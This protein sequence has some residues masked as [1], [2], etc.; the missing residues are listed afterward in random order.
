[1]AEITT[2]T[3]RRKPGRPKGYP[4]SGGR[5]KGTPNKSSQLGRDFIIKRG[6]PIETLC[7]IA[8]GEKIQAA[9]D[10]ASAAKRLGI[11][12]TID[13]RLAAARILAAK[14]VPDMKSVDLSADGGAPFVF[15]F[16]AGTTASSQ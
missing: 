14:I 11:F 10:T 3:E 7:K 2:A 5:A 12:P 4:R 6:A 9:A 8:K 15:Q 16:I 13:Q 1:M